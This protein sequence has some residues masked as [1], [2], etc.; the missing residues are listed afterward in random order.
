MTVELNRNGDGGFVG[1]T[2]RAFDLI[3]LVN[4]DFQVAVVSV[5]SVVVVFGV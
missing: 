3:S 4:D 5:V 2:Q 1:S